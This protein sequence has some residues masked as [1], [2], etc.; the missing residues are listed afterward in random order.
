LLGTSRH[1]TCGG[2]D[3]RAVS[4]REDTL[5]GESELVAGDPYEVYLY[6]P[7][8]YRFN[9]VT[10]AGVRV[11]DVRLEG[12]MRILRLESEQSGV[13]RWQVRYGAMED[14]RPSP[15]DRTPWP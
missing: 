9:G 4:W 3:L 2:P 13:V 5:S 11:V 14:Q 8:G 10:A 15:R 6:E 7:D 1:V 12:A